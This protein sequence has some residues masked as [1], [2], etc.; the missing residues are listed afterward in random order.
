MIVV[1]R[2]TAFSVLP[3]VRRQH[4]NGPPEE[5]GV[6][7]AEFMWRDAPVAFD[8]AELE[9]APGRPAPRAR[10]RKRSRAHARAGG[11]E[12]AHGGAEDPRV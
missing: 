3:A 2:A 10:P 5:G 6:W 9:P 8:A 11:A 7:Q 12:D 4:S 1:A